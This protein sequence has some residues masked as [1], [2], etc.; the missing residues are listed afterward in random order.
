MKAWTDYPIVELGDIPNKPAPIRECKPLDY[1]GD[2]YSRVM[3]E[4]IVTSFKS[5]YIYSAPGR[6]GD[7][8]VVDPHSYETG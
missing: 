5:G 8:P 2:K 1:D 6:C 4:G 3:V 7:V